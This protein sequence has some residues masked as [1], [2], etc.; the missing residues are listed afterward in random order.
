[1][2]VGESSY[3]CGLYVDYAGILR[4]VNPD[5]RSEDLTPYCSCCTH[6]FNGVRFGSQ[7]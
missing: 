6:T 1:M 3:Y 2:R 7:A 4:I 5:L